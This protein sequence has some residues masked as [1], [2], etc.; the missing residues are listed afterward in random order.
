MESSAVAFVN[1]VSKTPVDEREEVRPR[2]SPAGN[3]APL[4]VAPL[5]GAQADAEMVRRQVN[6]V[7]AEMLGRSQSRS[8]PGHG[9]SQESSTFGN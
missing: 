2:L 6:E 3:A 4:N 5:N 7:L 8:T 9:S 1:Q